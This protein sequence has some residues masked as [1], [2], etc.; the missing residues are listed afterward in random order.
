MGKSRQERRR[1]AALASYTAVGVLAGGLLGAML[2]AV[3]G[4]R[5]VPAAEVSHGERAFEPRTIEGSDPLVLGPLLGLL[6]GM[7]VGVATARLYQFALSHRGR[8]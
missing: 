1:S 7:F 2:G 4:A 3:A 5:Y 6:S 8:R